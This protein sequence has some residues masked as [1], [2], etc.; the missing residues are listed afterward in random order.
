MKIMALKSVK[1]SLHALRRIDWANEETC[2]FT[3]GLLSNATTVPFGQL[4]RLAKLV[5]NL[6]DFQ[7]WVGVYVVDDLLEFIRLALELNDNSLYQRLFSSVVY[8]GQLF[9]YTVCGTFMIFKV[10]G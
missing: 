7:P 1:S 9:N 4:E 2:E 5:G 6:T 8:L 3:L 10:G